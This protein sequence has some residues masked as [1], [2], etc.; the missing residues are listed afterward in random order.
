MAKNKKSVLG[1]RYGRALMVEEMSAEP[2]MI[3]RRF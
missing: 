3:C 2:S 1:G